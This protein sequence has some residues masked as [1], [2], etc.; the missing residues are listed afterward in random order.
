MGLN[1]NLFKSKRSAEDDVALNWKLMH[2]LP[3]Q[4]LFLLLVTGVSESMWYMFYLKGFPLFIESLYTL[5][6]Y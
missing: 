2:E 5:E 3:G 4:Q 1:R 6:L